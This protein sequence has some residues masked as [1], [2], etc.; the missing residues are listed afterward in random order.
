MVCCMARLIALH[1]DNP[2]L[3]LIDQVIEVLHGG[4][5]IVLPTDSSYALA[6]L[7]GQRSAVDRIV[8]IRQLDPRHDMTLLCRDLSNLGMFA[9]M[10]NSSYRLIKRLTPG[11]YT[12]LLKATK[13]VPR[14]LQHPQKKTIGLRVPAHNVTLSILGRLNEPLMSSSLILPGESLPETDADEINT[15]IGGQVDL[16][17]DGGA[18]GLE[19][20]TVLDLT[21]DIP[22]VVR[23]GRGDTSML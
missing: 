16:V 7:T 19:P 10:D 5:V 23:Q 20:T 12:F 3:R 21:K 9:R 15:R 18:G 6:C 2:Q 4:G 1:P 14:R 8:R 22:A 11:P 13:E 17:I